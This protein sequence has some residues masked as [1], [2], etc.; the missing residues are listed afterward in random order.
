LGSC[1]IFDDLTLAKAQRSQRFLSAVLFNFN[2]VFLG[3]LG[4]F[5]RLFYFL[6]G[7]AVRWAMPTLLI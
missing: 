4:V 2:D 6:A 5:A 7:K 3:V 1:R